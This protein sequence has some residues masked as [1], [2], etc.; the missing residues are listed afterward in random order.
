MK[1]YRSSMQDGAPS[2]PVNN[3]SV[4][5]NIAY[6]LPTLAFSVLVMGP[7]AILPGLYVKYFGFSLAAMALAKILARVFDG[8]TDPLMGYLSDRY[9][10]RRGT[11]KPLIA[12]GGVLLLLAGAMLYIPYGWDAQDPQP[13]SFAYFLFFYLSLTLAWTVM[14]IPHVSWGADLSS[15]VKGRSQRFSF[16]AIAIYVGPLLFFAL[17]LLPVFDSTEITPVTLKYIVYV[18]LVLLPLCFWVCLRWVPDPSRVPRPVI[19]P[20]AEKAQA[21]SKKQRLQNA[22][23]V[24]VGNRPLL[25]FLVAFGL[26][27]LAYSMS[28]GL[29]FFFVDNYLGLPEKMPYVF[30]VLFGAG[31]PAAWLWGYLAQKIGARST[32]AIGLS[33]CALGLLGIGFLR[34]D[35]SAFWPYLLCNALIGMGYTSCF[36]VGFMVLADI[37]DYGKWKFGQECTGIYFA[38][39]TT[40]MKLN[41]VGIAVGLLFA[42]W[43]GF[44]ASATVMSEASSMALRLPY[45]GLPIV[46]F[47]L[48]VVVIIRIPLDTHQSSSIRER[49][50]LGASR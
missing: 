5:E 3:N 38:F 21:L 11:R 33:L 24:V 36:V 19:T 14:Q 44:D 6:V 7:L 15:D 35:E 10:Q 42:Q 43:L 8:V 16:N 37:A 31:I 13:V 23:N 48:A 22:A 17:P 30:M 34:P 9:Q 40:I 12:L 32:W 47:I 18:S 50:A 25:V 29:T 1:T 28:Q 27:G 26:A 20:G 49:L 2:T 45:I 46:L 41:T 4:F 39:S